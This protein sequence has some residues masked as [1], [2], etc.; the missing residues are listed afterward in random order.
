MAAPRRLVEGACRSSH[1]SPPRARPLMARGCCWKSGTRRCWS[2]LS[3]HPAA[4][5]VADRFLA[6]AL[7]QEPFLQAFGRVAIHSAVQPAALFGALRPRFLG[8]RPVTRRIL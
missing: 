3:R 4:R 5:A 1:E 2:G 7:L 8:G 6:A